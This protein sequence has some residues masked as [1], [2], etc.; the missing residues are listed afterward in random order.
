MSDSQNP[1]L[2]FRVMDIQGYEGLALRKKK[3]EINM[4]LNLNKLFVVV[5]VNR[6]L[7]TVS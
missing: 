1:L 4:C 3:E 6:E 2:T 7:L 5:F